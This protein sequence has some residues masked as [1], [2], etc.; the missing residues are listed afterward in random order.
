MGDVGGGAARYLGPVDRR[1]QV[2]LHVI[3]DLGGPLD[4]LEGGEPLTQ[5]PDLLVDLVLTDLYRVDG[6]LDPRQVGQGDL[7]PDVDLGG[8]PQRLAVGELGDLD[9]GPAEAL[10]LV[11]PDGGDDLPRNGV[12]DGLVEYRT[13]ADALVDHGRRYLALPEAR[14]RDLRGDLP[15]RLLEARF[16]FAERHLDG[17]LHPCRAQS[18]D[19]ALHWRTP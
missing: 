7:G 19:G 13:P 15:V 12:L 14:Y 1:G 8:E 17:E 5:G 16:E 6:H 10:D 3:A 4:G 18:L 11:L 2:D 9:R